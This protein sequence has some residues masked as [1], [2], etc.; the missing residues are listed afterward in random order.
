[1]GPSQNYLSY[2]GG[3]DGWT[4]QKL[5]QIDTSNVAQLQAP[6]APQAWD[7]RRWKACRW[8]WMNRVRLW[9]RRATSMPDAKTGLTLWRFHRKQDVVNPYQINPPTC[10]AVLD[11]R[12]LRHP[13]RQSDRPRTP[14]PD[15]NCGKCGSPT[16]W[17]AS[18]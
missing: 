6:V 16:H 17:K 14:I 12:V 9:A 7:N 3:Y 18:P 13:G 8:W 2:W 5:K 10:V 4:F 15:G 1:V 11:G